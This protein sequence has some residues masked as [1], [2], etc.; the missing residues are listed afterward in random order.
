MMFNAEEMPHVAKM[1]N[2]GIRV[3]KPS[4]KES[5]FRWKWKVVGWRREDLLPIP[6]ILVQQRVPVIA[7][8]GVP[9][10][11]N[12]VTRAFRG[13]AFLLCIWV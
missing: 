2:A 8:K 10:L 9:S 7:G 12:V 11:K 4:A 1:E 13:S 5:L 3:T 6:P